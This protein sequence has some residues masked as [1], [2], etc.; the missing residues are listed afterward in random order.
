MSRV[1]LVMVALLFAC[2]LAGAEMYKWVDDRGV[3]K[4]AKRV[5]AYGD[6]DFDAAPNTTSAPSPAP[7][8]VAASAAAKPK[9]F[10]GT[11]QIYL[12]EWCGY[13]KKAV[14]YMDRNGIAY[15]AYDIEK[16]PAAKQRYDRMGGRGV[17]LIIVGSNRMSG[18]S[19]EGLEQYL[20]Q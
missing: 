14:K 4:K 18:F 2:P 1:L 17:P 15:V 16:D 3:M 10:A 9:R 11:V 20:Q 12:T 7:A 13:C 5:K 19:E 6:G 8:R